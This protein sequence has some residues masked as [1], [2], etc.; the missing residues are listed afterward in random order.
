MFCCCFSRAV[1]LYIYPVQT[2]YPI[3]LHQFHS[4]L[5]TTSPFPQLLSLYKPIFYSHLNWFLHPKKISSHC[6][7]YLGLT[8]QY[9]LSFQRIL[10]LIYLSIML[11]VCHYQIFQETLC[12]KCIIKSLIRGSEMI[13][14]AWKEHYNRRRMPYKLILSDI[15]VFNNYVHIIR[16]LRVQ[17][18]IV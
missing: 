15:L 14:E 8:S 17:E 1:V 13:K 10:F 18:C 11:S 6:C 5:S 9:L 4:Q 12:N 2:Y 7:F 16:Y 3:K